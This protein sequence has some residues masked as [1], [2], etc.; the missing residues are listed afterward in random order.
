MVSL[1]E[2]LLP[3]RDPTS[4]GDFGEG[5]CLITGPYRR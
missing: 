1:M 2:F 3:T 4:L 5:N